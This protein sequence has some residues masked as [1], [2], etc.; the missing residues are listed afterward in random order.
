MTQLTDNGIYAY[1]IPS[2]AFGIMINN[3][4]SESELMYMLSMS[5]IADDDSAEETLIAKPLPPGQYE[6]LFTT[7]NAT[8]EDA[9]KVVESDELFINGKSQGIRYCDYR[10]P[11]DVCEWFKYPLPSL[12]SLLRSKSLEGNHAIIKKF[13]P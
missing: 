13:N 10:Y 11:N 2:M 4:G 7:D 6:F 5:D 8:E 9:R 3:Y 1:S 12:I